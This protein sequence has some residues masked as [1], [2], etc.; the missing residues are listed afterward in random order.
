MGAEL[1]TASCHIDEYACDTI[2]ELLKKWKTDKTILVEKEE[3]KDF[4]KLKSESCFRFNILNQNVCNQ[5][6]DPWTSTKAENNE[7]KL[8]NERLKSE[9]DL[10]KRNCE[11][12]LNLIQNPKK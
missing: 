8:D 4:E 6:S 10:M 12:I 3:K 5:A 7:L 2:K 1:Q 11:N 9:N